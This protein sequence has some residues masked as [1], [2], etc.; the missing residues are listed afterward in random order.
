MAKKIQTRLRVEKCEHIA[1]NAI[2]LG[3]SSGVS[4]PEIKAGQFAQ[5]SAPG[6]FLKHPFSIHDVDLSQGRL[7]F[8]IQVV[9]PTTRALESLVEGDEIDALLPLG[10]GFQTDGSFSNALLVGG[11]VGTAP[12][13]LLGRQLKE[14][15]R[16]FSFLLGARSDRQLLRM[17]QFEGLGT[18]HVATQDGSMGE[19]GLVTEHS[20]LEGGRFDRIFCCGPT[21]MM[22]A[23]A[24][25]A[26]SHDIPCQVSLEHSM[27]CGIGACLCC[28]EDTVDGNVCVC[29]EGPVFDTRKLK[30]QI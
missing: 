25:Y 15:G 12:L 18:V 14:Q 2:L 6:V 24:A 22:K 5:L 10:N 16:N 3:V 27:A 29:R 21:P 4:L 19:K 8:L 20:I 23:V 7:D 1:G 30:W 26:A 17:E 28:V 9:G 13:F 11:G